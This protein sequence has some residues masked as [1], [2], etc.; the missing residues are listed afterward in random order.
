MSLGCKLARKS[1]SRVI[2]FLFSSIRPGKTSI[3]FIHCCFPLG[4][5]DWL[6][7]FFLS[8]MQNHENKNPPKSIATI[9]YVFLVFFRCF[10]SIRIVEKMLERSTPWKSWKRPPSKV[11]K[12]KLMYH[13]NDKGK[14][15][16]QSFIQFKSL[17]TV[18]NLQL[19]SISLERLFLA[20][21]TTLLAKLN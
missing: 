5:I 11:R 17:E 2:W 12:I 3:C 15:R 4:S 6:R 8:V 19:S 16:T 21:F 20:L 14:L 1:S 9:L 7:L 10:W 13:R 18:Q